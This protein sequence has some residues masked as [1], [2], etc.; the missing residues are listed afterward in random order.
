MTKDHFD[1]KCCKKA[2][3]L[4]LEFF[5]GNYLKTMYW[6]YTPNPQLGDVSPFTMICAGREDKLLK[7][8]EI[9]IDENKPPH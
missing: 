6:F 4:V 7:F 5:Q 8:I 9:A 1:D 3:E 2:W